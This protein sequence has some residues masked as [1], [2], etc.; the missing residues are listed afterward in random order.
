MRTPNGLNNGELG[1]FP[2]Y[3]NAQIRCARYWLKL[4]RM[5]EQ[6]LPFKAYKILCNLDERGKTNWV[7]NVRCF[8]SSYGFR[9][10]WDSHGVGHIDEFLKVFRQR[11]IDCRWQCL[12][13][14]IQT[15]ERFSF[16]KKF[17]TSYEME[18][19]LLLDINRYVKCSLTRFI[20]GISDIFFYIV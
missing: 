10:V 18:P 6:R 15:S 4:T 19:Y 20:F 11:L 16:Y 8:L 5:S 3:I 12:D 13:D 1:R 9:Y 7:S 14:H 2:I 17:K